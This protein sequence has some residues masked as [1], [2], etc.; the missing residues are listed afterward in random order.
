MTDNLAGGS[1]HAGRHAKP[2]RALIVDDS[3]VMRDTLGV[4]LQVQPGIEVVGA[5]PSGQET[6]RQAQALRPDLVILDVQMAGMNGLQT[7]E[8][9]RQM[10]PDMPVILISDFDF[11]ELRQAGRASGAESFLAKS[12]LHC[13]LVE[14]IRR[15]MQARRDVDGHAAP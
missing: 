6:L 3:Q 8:Q 10:H 12:R 4:F 14:E 15:V 7:T 9:L 1:S 2:I 13:D 5:A 11:P